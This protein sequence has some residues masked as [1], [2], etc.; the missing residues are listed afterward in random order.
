MQNTL[1][2]QGSSNTHLDY[3]K[4]ELLSDNEEISVVEDEHDDVQLSD[5]ENVS[6]DQETDDEDSKNFFPRYGS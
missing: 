6:Q 3:L 5:I 4:N 2:M 1:G